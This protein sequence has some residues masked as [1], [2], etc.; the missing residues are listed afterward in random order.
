MAMRQYVG[1][2]Y[3]PLFDG[4]WSATKSYEPLTIVMYGNT[5]YI[6]KVQVPAGTLPTNNTYWA[7]TG[8]YN[9]QITTI[10]NRLDDLE[11]QISNVSDNLSNQ[12]L[13]VSEDL[14]DYKNRNILIVTDIPSYNN[15][16]YPTV[17]IESGS[18]ENNNWFNFWE[19]YPNKMNVTKIVIIGGANENFSNRTINIP[20]NLPPVKYIFAYDVWLYVEKR[21]EIYQWCEAIES[22]IPFIN[23]TGIIRSQYYY[24]DYQPNA[25]FYANIKNYIK[26][27]I[28]GTYNYTNYYPSLIVDSHILMKAGTLKFSL[29]NVIVE[30][31]RVTIDAIFNH[32][33]YLNPAKTTI[34]L[35]ARIYI[36]NQG[37]Y[38]GQLVISGIDTEFISYTSIPNG[39]YE[40]GTIYIQN[41]VESCHLL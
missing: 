26:E 8:N 38:N 4:N 10:N 5:S 35:L 23:T 29:S 3:V 37:E 33:S 21:Q 39:T 25:S 32:L 40:T 20:S 18:I 11:S 36:P 16:G 6:S 14:Q 2:R 24:N 13:S 28:E 27:S 22:K 1:A 9:G 12:I 34:E 17:V 30:S 41:L 19:N 31:S 7:E 15:L